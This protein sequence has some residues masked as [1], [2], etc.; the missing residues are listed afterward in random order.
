[1]SAFQD[2]TGKRFGRLRVMWPSGYQGAQR[3]VMWACVCDDG[4][5]VIVNGN[6]L[7]RNHTQSCGCFRRD[8]SA[9]RIKH[10]MSRTAENEAYKQA[11][12][13]CNNPR[14]TGYKNYG[15]RGIKFLFQ[16]FNEF[17]A[18]L[19]KKPSPELSLDRINNN[20]HYQSG[21]VRW[22]TRFQQS[23]NRRKKGETNHVV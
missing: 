4:N 9:L 19:G 3:M 18:H 17:F 11:K 21:N 10:G 15:G 22:A 20:G 8:A 5:F 12:A 14:S 1:M 13:R 6:N 7:R 16:S 23:N 2:F